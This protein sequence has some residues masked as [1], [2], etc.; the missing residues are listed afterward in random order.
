MEYAEGGSLYNVLH[1]NP[2]LR[3]NMAHAMSWA[4]QCAEV[5]LLVIHILSA[6]ILKSKCLF[7]GCC[8]F[9]FD[10]SKSINSS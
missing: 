7:L 4:K 9:A 5:C 3:Y 10:A 1:C 8:L 6:P 2:K